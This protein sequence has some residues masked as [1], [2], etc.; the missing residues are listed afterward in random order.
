LALSVNKCH[1]LTTYNCHFQDNA[2]AYTIT[3]KHFLKWAIVIR[4]A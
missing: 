4:A 1:R 3:Y 2:F